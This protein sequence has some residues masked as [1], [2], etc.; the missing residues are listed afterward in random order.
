MKSVDGYDSFIIFTN[1]YSDMVIF[2]QSKKDL[3][4]WINLRYSK[5]KLKINMIKE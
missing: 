5:L 4:C 1:D 3:K 2:I